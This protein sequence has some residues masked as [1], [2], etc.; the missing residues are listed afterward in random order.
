MSWPAFSAKAIR[1]WPAS[2]ADIGNHDVFVPIE[3]LS[4]FGAT[5][6]RLSQEKVDLRQ[7]ERRPGEFLL[8][9]DVLGHRLIDVRSARF[10]GA[11]DVELAGRG[12]EF[13]SR[14]HTRHRSRIFG[15]LKARSPEPPATDWKAF[16]PLIGLTPRVQ[17][18]GRLLR[19]RRLHPA[20]LRR[21]ARGSLGG[22]GRGHPGH[23]APRPRA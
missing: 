13:P 1:T 19:L 4:A 2:V 18:R 10:V 17:H 22:R 14:D 6:V 15:L 20:Q 11:Y 21:P 16:E 8:R 9:A 5:Q 7:F 23:R 12:R 3:Q